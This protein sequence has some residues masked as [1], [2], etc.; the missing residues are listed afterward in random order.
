[1][2]FEAIFSFWLLLLV[3]LSTESTKVCWMPISIDA[4]RTP[5]AY[6]FCEG[7]WATVTYD[8]WFV[9]SELFSRKETVRAERKNWIDIYSIWNC[10]RTKFICS[11]FLHLALRW[12]KTGTNHRLGVEAQ[13][14]RMTMSFSSKWLLQDWHTTSRHW[15]QK[16]VTPFIDLL[17]S[18]WQLFKI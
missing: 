17:T 10:K 4:P 15:G 12:R 13:V 9:H 8:E 11:P 6:S 18:L 3:I 2:F 16:G 5:A 1:M 14:S 7:D